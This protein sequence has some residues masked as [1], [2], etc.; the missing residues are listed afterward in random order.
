MSPF[1]SFEQQEFIE[2]ERAFLVRV[3]PISVARARSLAAYVRTIG[4]DFTCDRVGSLTLFGWH[5]A[6]SVF[7]FLFGY[8]AGTLG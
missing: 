5:A 2:A 6:T 1:R 8:R 3:P 7:P 4:S